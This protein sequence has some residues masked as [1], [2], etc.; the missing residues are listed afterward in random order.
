MQTL[1]LHIASVLRAHH[2]ERARLVNQ[3]RRYRPHFS[4]GDRVRCLK[5]KSLWS[6]AKL[7]AR[8]AGPMTVQQRNGRS[9][10]TVRDSYG[11]L[12]A[13]HMDQLKPFVEDIL[14]GISQGYEGPGGGTSKAGDYTGPSETA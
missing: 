10:Y 12:H 14:V 5:P 1:D 13:V 9:S 8:W 7:E 2:E 4:I 6:K 3:G 11:D